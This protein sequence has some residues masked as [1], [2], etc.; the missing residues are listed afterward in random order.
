MN[1]L[2]IQHFGNSTMGWTGPSALACDGSDWIG[3][4]FDRNSLHIGLVGSNTTHYSS[5]TQPKLAE[6]Q[7]DSDKWIIYYKVLKFIETEFRVLQKEIITIPAKQSL[8]SDGV[9]GAKQSLCYTPSMILF[10]I[11]RASHAIFEFSVF[12]VSTW[13]WAGLR[14]DRWATLWL[15]NDKPLRLSGSRP[16][17]HASRGSDKP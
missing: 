17:S 5:W 15:W 16:N 9:L 14:R 4:S 2:R 1:L 3:L 7:I 12:V 6:L 8:Y 11:N 10:L 13:E